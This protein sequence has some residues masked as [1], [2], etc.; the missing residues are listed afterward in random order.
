MGIAKYFAGADGSIQLSER[1]TLV[2]ALKKKESAIIL[3]GNIVR[4]AELASKLYADA[5]NGVL[6]VFQA[7][8]G[9]GKDSSIK[10]ALSGI[11]PQIINVYNFKKPTAEELSHDYLWRCARRAPQRGKIAVFNRSHYEDVLVVKVHRLW[12][13][14]N[15]QERCKTED[16]IERRYEHIINW[17]KYLWENGIITVKIFLH[18]SQEEQKNRFLNRIN[19][20]DKNWKFEE[21]DLRERGFW[22]DYQIAYQEAIARTST[23]EAPWYVVPAD[24]KRF[25]HTV[26]S[27]IVINTLEELDPSYPKVKKKQKEL[28]ER[29]KIELLQ[30]I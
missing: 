26:V 3:A 4:K 23:M 22:E 10:H 24:N 13:N 21:S 25:A 2:E 14:L 18:L 8:D 17:E 27:E 16:I 29:A 15:I 5:K 6:F 12:E 20:P 1:E 19:R 7:M 9:A 11:N 28:L 30:E